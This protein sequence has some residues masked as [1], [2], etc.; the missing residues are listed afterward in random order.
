MCAANSLSANDI[1][2]FLRSQRKDQDLRTASNSIC[3][4]LTHL[5][6]LV[7]IDSPVIGTADLVGAD[8]AELGLDRVRR[9]AAA[10]VE[11]CRGSRSKAVRGR[12]VAW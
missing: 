2:C 5:D 3:P 10:F 8:M 9:P 6:P 4:P 1:T 11:K 7:P 12:L